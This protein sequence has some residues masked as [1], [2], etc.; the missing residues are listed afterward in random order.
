[1]KL[2]ALDTSTEACTIALHYDG[3]IILEHEVAP[4]QHANI[5]LPTIKKLLSESSLSLSQLDALAFGR[6]PGSFTGIRI[7]ASVIQGLAFSTDLPVIPVSTLQTMAQGAFR[8]YQVKRVLVALDA[9]MQE[10]YFGGFELDENNLMQEC[11]KECVC[12]PESIQLESKTD[13]I[14]IGPGWQVYEPQLAHL[15]TQTHDAYPNAQDMI[16]LAIAAF[17]LGHTVSA[18]KAIPVYLRDKVVNQ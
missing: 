11:I 4:R 9:R 15:V 8:V 6:G 7:A 3:Q 1:M 10:V 5:V 14:G 2:L 18:E 16:P 13:W 17:E 12:S